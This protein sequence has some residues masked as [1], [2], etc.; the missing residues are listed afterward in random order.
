MSGAIILPQGISGMQSSGYGITAALVAAIAADPALATLPLVRNPRRPQHLARGPLVLIVAEK[1]DTLITNP[2][3]AELRRRA[4][5]LGAIARG[6]GDAVEAAADALYQRLHLVTFTALRELQRIPQSVVR[7]IAERD[8]QFS[9][10]ELDVDG[11]VVVG[12]WE[13]DYR[14]VRSPG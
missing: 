12:G 8:V 5:T 9:V 3:S 2:G 11:A 10:E 6:D 1:G 13:I 4:I 7:K 14:Y